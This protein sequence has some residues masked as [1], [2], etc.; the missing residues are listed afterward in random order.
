[1][2][3]KY[4]A[5]IFLQI[6]NTLYKICPIFSSKSK[7]ESEILTKLF[8]NFNLNIIYENII[9]NVT[10]NCIKIFTDYLSL[11]VIYSK[12]RLCNVSTDTEFLLKK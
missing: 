6:N 12:K 5:L 1:M 9:H 10:L 7:Q 2:S 11:C 8:H 4:S 3:I